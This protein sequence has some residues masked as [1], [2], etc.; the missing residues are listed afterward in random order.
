LVE[1]V[2]ERDQMLGGLAEIDDTVVTTERFEALD[3]VA[4]H[5]CAKTLAHHAVQVD[6]HAEPEQVVDLVLPSGEA[7]HQSPD[8]LLTRSVEFGEMVDGGRL[9]VVVVVDVQM[10]VLRPSPG[11]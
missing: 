2:L 10:G 8:Y 4:L 3:G 11:D 1:R 9:V 6:E 5:P 7:A